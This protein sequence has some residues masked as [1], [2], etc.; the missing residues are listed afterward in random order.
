[1]KQFMYIYIII[2][3]NKYTTI[4]MTTTQTSTIPLMY[5]GFLFKKN[6]AGYIYPTN[7]SNGISLNIKATADNIENVKSI[8]D[9]INNG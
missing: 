9:Q 6:E 4:Y 3:A 5:G 1:M 2:K 7:L 8:I